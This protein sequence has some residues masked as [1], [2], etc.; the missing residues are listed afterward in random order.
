MSTLP[1]T[2]SCRRAQQPFKKTGVV[3]FNWYTNPRRDNSGNAPGFTT[4]CS[5]FTFSVSGDTTSLGV[6]GFF[7]FLKNISNWEKRFET[8]GT[9]ARDRQDFSQP[10]SFQGLW[11][12]PDP[13]RLS[14]SAGT[15]WDKGNTWKDLPGNTLQ[16]KRKRESKTQKGRTGDKNWKWED[17]KREVY[18]LQNCP[19]GEGTVELLQ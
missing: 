18:R 5:A 4:D 19:G 14:S 7:I 16:Q 10:H 6:C 8:E 3:T 12:T 1:P 11:L 15:T 13:E 2:L 17:T 9:R